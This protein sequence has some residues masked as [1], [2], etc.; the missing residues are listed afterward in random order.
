MR[1]HSELSNIQLLEALDHQPEN[2]A[3]TRWAEWRPTTILDAS[4]PSPT[5]SDL[6]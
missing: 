6:A 5:F 2:T 4:R 3:W 1:G